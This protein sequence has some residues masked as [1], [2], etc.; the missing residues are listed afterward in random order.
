MLFEKFLSEAAQA[1]KNLSDAYLLQILLALFSYVLS[2][3]SPSWLQ[4]NWQKIQLQAVTDSR[5]LENDK[6]SH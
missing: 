3:Q 6:R 5:H 4:I 2:L 1:E